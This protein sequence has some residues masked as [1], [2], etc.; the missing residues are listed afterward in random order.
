VDETVEIEKRVRAALDALGEPFEIMPCDPEFADT[1]AFCEHYGVP[2]GN[3][4]NTILVASKKSPK[5]YA[6]CI[7]LASTRLDVNHAVRSVMGAGRLSFATAEE[8]IQETGMMIGGVTPFGLPEG[9]PVYIDGRV[10]E[11]DHVVI[12]GGSRSSKIKIAP[13]ALERMPNVTFVD[14]LATEPPRR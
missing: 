1:A 8:T 3:S 12:G 14:G 4:G 2:P 5:Q 10:A 9:L 13:G 6:L 11:L 7:A